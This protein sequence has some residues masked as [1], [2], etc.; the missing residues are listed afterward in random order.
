MNDEIPQF[1]SKTYVGEISENAEKNTP[2]TFLGKSM[3]PEVYDHDQGT[4]GTF[5]LFL[6]GDGNVF[7]VTPSMGI[8]DATFMIRVKNQ[9]KIDFEQTKVINF[10]IVAKEA[11]KNGRETRASV[12]IYV[13]DQNDNPPQFLEERYEVFIAEDVVAGDTIA[14]IEADD[15]D[16]GVFGVAGLRYT[17]LTGPVSG[18][19]VLDN[20]T[21]VVTMGDTGFS[22]DKEIRDNHYLMVEAR[23]QEGGGNRNTV[24]LIIYLEDVN[25]NPPIFRRD[26][27]ESFIQENSPAFTTP[28][29]VE[30][31]DADQNG[32]ENCEVRYRILRGDQYG[33]FTINS[34][35]GE[36]KPNGVLDYELLPG[37]TQAKMYNMTIRA[38]DLGSPSLWSDVPVVVYIVDQNDNAP[39][40]PVTD[41]KVTI[42]ED[43]PGGTPIIQVNAKDN[44]G[45]SPNNQIV[46]RIHTGAK[47]K[48]VI[49]S[50]SG[51]ISVSQG[52]NLDP[53]QSIPATTYYVLE[54]LA[55]DGGIGDDKLSSRVMV[56]VS[57]TDVNNKLPRIRKTRPVEISEDIPIGELVTT[58]AA[59]DSD[60]DSVLRFRV[61]YA[62]SQARDEEG[63][64]IELTDF[65]WRGMFSLDDVDGGIR[66]AARLDRELIQV[67]EIVSSVSSLLTFFFCYQGV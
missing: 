27:Y 24:E 43:T 58:I 35:S 7:E 63:R 30:A 29:I 65:D 22:F 25:D 18:A 34:L 40:F 15:K 48:F 3:I 20:I 23:D 17:G 33:N 12:T 57:I 32:T 46:Y 2:V 16:S 53:D 41:Y 62:Q 47:D 54:V 51:M 6:E 64:R 59:S 26:Y 10:M 44:D 36:I 13:R 14:R 9:S 50:E 55:M 11:I 45:S 8:N 19:L 21:G 1:K 67:G 49:N 42:P 60:Q 31:T 61:D 28:F 38:F 4:N 37:S 39:Q 66:T 5:K 52:A 56:N